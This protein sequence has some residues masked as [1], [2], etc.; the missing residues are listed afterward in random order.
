MRARIAFARRSP[1]ARMRRRKHQG[2]TSTVLATLFCLAEI[3]NTAGR[4]AE[5][6]AGAA[7]KEPTAFLKP[8]P[9]G[10]AMERLEK[11]LTSAIFVESR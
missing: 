7:A 5:T 11:A 8:R 9:E 3:S 2:R 4:A 10:A 6:R 1:F